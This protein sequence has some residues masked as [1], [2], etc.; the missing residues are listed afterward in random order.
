MIHSRV[1]KTT[2]SRKHVAFEM[3]HYLKPVTINYDIKTRH[4]QNID[5][6]HLHTKHNFYVC[7]IKDT[8]TMEK[9]I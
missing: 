7:T 1:S 8:K 6:Y 9:L 4:I 3:R 2:R 5:N